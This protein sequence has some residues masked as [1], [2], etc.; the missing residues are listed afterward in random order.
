MTTDTALAIITLAA[1]FIHYMYSIFANQS[2]LQCFLLLAEHMDK[3]E[4]TNEQD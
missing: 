4:S 1:V 3:N 2:I